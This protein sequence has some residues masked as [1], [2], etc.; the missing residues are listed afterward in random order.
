MLERSNPSITMPAEDKLNDS[1]EIVAESAEP[2]RVNEGPAETT[3][4]SEV[5]IDATTGDVTSYK[6]EEEQTESDEEVSL[7]AKRAGQSLKDLAESVAM[8]A[9]RKV[10]EVKD[11]AVDNRDSVTPAALDAKKDAQDIGNLGTLV[12]GPARIFEQMMAEI[13]Q[14]D[15]EAQDRLLLGYKKLLEEQVNVID[16]RRGMAKRLKGAAT[17]SDTATS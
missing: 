11:K 17:F 2:V 7:K 14:Y 8:A 10:K 3:V 13:M 1:D 15:F 4:E 6:V 9:K 12:E 16:A 5:V